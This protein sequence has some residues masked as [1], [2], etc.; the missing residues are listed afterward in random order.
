MKVAVLGASGILGQHMRLCVPDEIEAVWV[1]RQADKLHL[2][3]NLENPHEV[4]R[5]LEAEQPDVIVNLAGESRVDIVERQPI[6]TIPINIA[7]PEALA[8][9]CFSRGKH[10]VHISSQAVFSGD[11]PPYYPD[12]RTRPVNAYGH[13][14]ALAEKRVRRV[15][16]GWTIARATLV[17]GIRPLNTGR[18]NPIEQ[19]LEGQNRQ[20]ADRWFSVL[21]ADEGAR[22]I[23][24]LAIERKSREIVHL[25]LWGCTNRYEIAQKLGCAVEPAKH[26]DFSGI[27]P[28]P[29]NTAYGS[30]EQYSTELDL[31]LSTC[32]ALWET[33]KCAA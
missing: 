19:I 20:V 8:H 29:V 16:W 30:A 11:H 33:K 2:G 28:R 3:V 22:Q 21:F 24:N 12:S 18:P 6:A 32:R 17:L 7:L 15:Q 4:I 10:Y 13:Q 14:K 9:Y 25:G 23:W 31:G 1:R 5:F 27:A 26:D